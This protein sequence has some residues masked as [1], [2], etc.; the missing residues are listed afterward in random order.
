MGKLKNLSVGFPFLLFSLFGDLV[1]T[2]G[3]YVDASKEEVDE[4]F[5]TTDAGSS[6]WH[7]W[8]PTGQ[9]YNALECC[10]FWVRC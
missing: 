9:Q 2:Q 5:Q 10:N 4:G 3:E 7:K 8:G 6:S 1:S